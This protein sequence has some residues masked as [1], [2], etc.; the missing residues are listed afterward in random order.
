MGKGVKIFFE[1]LFGLMQ[2]TV[3]KKIHFSVIRQTDTTLL[4]EDEYYASEKQKDS[5]GLQIN[6][7]DFEFLKNDFIKYFE[8]FDKIVPSDLDQATNVLEYLH[9]IM[10]LM[11][12]ISFLGGY[13]KKIQIE[14]FPLFLG[15]LSKLAVRLEKS[16]YSQKIEIPKRASFELN[17]DLVRLAS[18]IIHTSQDGQDFLIDNGFILNFLNFSCYDS[19]NPL[20]REA[21]ILFIRYVTDSNQRARDVISELRVR[22]LDPES[23]NDSTAKYGTDFM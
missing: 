13:N 19:N 21:T 20:S 7:R 23:L 6:F 11:I 3:E 9:W 22:D 4:D 2:K 12:P 8:I 16:Y 17:T 18:N 5:C 10:K 1:Y 15:A 14:F